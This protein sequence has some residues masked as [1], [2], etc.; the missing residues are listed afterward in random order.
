MQIVDITAEL[1]G[2]DFAPSSLF[3]E[4][5]QNIKTILT[6]TIYSVPLDRE[7]G[8]NISMLD[9]PIQVAQAKLTAEIMDKI[10]RFEPRVKVTKVLYQGDG[11]EGTLR[12][13]VR[14]VIKDEYL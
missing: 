5:I 13:T 3:L 12:P 2:V 6:T 11:L 9:T 7:L 1:G 14:V 10:K 8:L 4:I